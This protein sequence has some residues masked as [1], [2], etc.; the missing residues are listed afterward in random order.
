MKRGVVCSI[1]E[2][3]AYKKKKECMHGAYGRKN[4]K[5]VKQQISEAIVNMNTILMEERKGEEVSTL[6]FPRDTNSVS[7]IED[8]IPIDKEEN[9]A[10]NCIEKKTDS[11]LHSDKNGNCNIFKASTPNWKKNTKS[12][13]RKF[14]KVWLEKDTMSLDLSCNLFQSTREMIPFVSCAVDGFSRF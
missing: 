12:I 10:Q 1:D 5:M 6:S 7:H 13:E 3:V 2:G 4:G 11:D 14:L 9:V 8:K